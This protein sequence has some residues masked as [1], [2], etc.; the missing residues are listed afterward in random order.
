MLPREWVEKAEFFRREAR[1]H[2][3]EGVYWAACFE[4]QQAVELYLKALQV[5]LM[6]THEFTHDLSKL[7]RSLEELGL[8]VPQGLYAVADALTP[9]YTMAR[10]PGRKP[11]VYDRSMGERCVRYMEEIIA[12]VERVASRRGEGAGEATG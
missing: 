3:E 9:H 1:R 10:Y 12:W 2:L 4:A 8:E 7:L 11:V 6:G 5:S